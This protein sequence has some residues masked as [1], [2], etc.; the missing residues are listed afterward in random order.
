M[1]NQTNQTSSPNKV[2]LLTEIARNARLVWRLLSDARVSTL[3]K[4]A[5]PGL[6]A[7]YLLWPADLLPDVFLG[8]GQLDDLALLALAIKFFIDLCP[9]DIVRE[10]RS[11]VAGVTP[12]AQAKP[13]TG[14]ADAVV[15][16]EYRILE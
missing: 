9:A 2:G 13:D 1:A 16:A 15:D 14:K 7:A 12:P 3:T 4:L 10:H 5:I 6:A 11:V 8:L